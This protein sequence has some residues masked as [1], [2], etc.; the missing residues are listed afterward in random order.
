MKLDIEKVRM[1]YNS[2]KNVWGE[3]DP[4]HNYSKKIISSFIR[5]QN[6][7]ENSFVLNA[8]SAGNSYNI[9]C[10]L[11]YHVDIA[12]T[13]IKNIE[14][15]FVASVEALPFDKNTF[16]NVI[17][18]GSVLNYCDVFN[19]ISEL[20]RVLKPGGHLI[21]EFESSWGYEYLGKFDYKKNA[22]IITTQYIEDQHMQW[23][24]APN[25]VKK[26]LMSYDFQVIN[27]YSFHIADGILSKFL[28]DKTA[29]GITQTIDKYLIHVNPFKKHGNNVIYHC[30]KQVH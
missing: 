12:E 28:D 25:Y 9:N 10:R 21:I 17:C 4:W 16:D 6:F 14:N 8:G 2:V 13:K 15:S 23:L 30:I 11:M 5:K 22:C 18:V 20:S 1:F 7:F 27:G 29:V 19:A 24:Y 3:N 26:I